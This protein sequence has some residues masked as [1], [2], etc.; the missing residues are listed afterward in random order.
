MAPTMVTFV[1]RA[2]CK[3]FLKVNDFRNVMRYFVKSYAEEH[4]DREQRQFEE[5][6]GEDCQIEKIDVNL[7]VPKANARV[8]ILDRFF[9]AVLERA[10]EFLNKYLGELCNEPR[11]LGL[12]ARQRLV[13]TN[14][15]QKER[16]LRR[17][18]Y[19]TKLAQDIEA[20]RLERELRSKEHYNKLVRDIEAK[21][22]RNNE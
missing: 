18:E 21:R 16:E 8:A 22:E 11:E 13:R 1:R 4:A 5:K 15:R 2:E 6:Y 20:A 12:E 9:Q 19:H 14:A 3:L 10:H 17:K 7:I